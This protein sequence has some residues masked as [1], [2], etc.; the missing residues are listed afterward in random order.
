MNMAAARWDDVYRTRP[1][2][3]GGL[4]A[5]RHQFGLKLDQRVDR[6]LPV[7][8]FVLRMSP[9]SDNRFSMDVGLVGVEIEVV[10]RSRSIAVRVGLTNANS[11][12]PFRN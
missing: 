7:G 2:S 10:L 3:V 6:W 9:G 12:L 8:G 5:V 1:A 4:F 11:S